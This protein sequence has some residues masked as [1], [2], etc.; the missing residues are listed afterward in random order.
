MRMGGGLGASRPGWCVSHFPSFQ[1]NRPPALRFGATRRVGGNDACK[2]ARALRE[3][4]GA[5]MSEQ[6]A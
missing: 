5:G 6:C 3:S 2:L 4:R 1:A